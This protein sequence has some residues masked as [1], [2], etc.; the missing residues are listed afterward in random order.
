MPWDAPDRETGPEPA[1]RPA[2]P[3]L[4][5][6]ALLTTRWGIWAGAL[7]LLMAA[8]FLVRYAVEQ[9]LLGPAVRCTLAALLGLTFIVGA[10]WLRRRDKA[11][12]SPPDA[13]AEDLPGRD[14]PG[15]SE[16]DR[17]L[18]PGDGA[19]AQAAP[20]FAFGP[21]LAPAALAAGGVGAL[22]GAAYGAGPLYGLIS[23]L[24][25][26]VLMA[27]ASLAGLALAL[28]H[29]QMVAAIGLVGAFVTPLLVQTQEPSLPGL[30]AYLLFVAAAALAVVRYTAWVWLGWATTIAGAIWVLTALAMG[31]G[32]DAW[33]PAFFVP[34]VATLNLWLLPPAALDHPIGRRLAWVPVAVLGLTGLALCNDLQSWETRAGVLLLAPLT[35]AKAAQEAR[36]RLLPFLAA[37]LALLL[38][39]FWSMD[40]T[41]W[42]GPLDHP[43]NWTPEVVRALI[44]TAALI[45]GFF[46]AAGL[47]FQNRRPQPLPWASLTA[48]VPV[49][50]LAI[51]YW[52]VALFQTR[53]DWA[54]VAFALS[55]GLTGAASLTMRGTG[56]FGVTAWAA[57]EDAHLHR[58][59][60]G[61]HAAGAVAALSL[62][63]AMVLAD[64]WLTL[65][66]S[67]MLPALAWVEAQSDLPPLRRVALAVAIL[68]LLRLLANWYVLDYAFGR[69]PL[70][71]GLLAAY[72]VPAA[73]FWI[74]A[75]MFRRRGDDV[76]VAVLEAGSM[77]FATVLVALEIRQAA[78]EGSLTGGSFSFGEAALHVSSLAAMSV[79]TMRIATRLQ[80]PVLDW[81]WRVQGALALFGGVALLVPGNPLFT[82]QP[83]GAWPLADW[84][85][86]A[87]LLPAG[88]AVLAMHHP[89]TGQP[90]LL[91]R[92]LGLYAM[93][94]GF[95]WL[96]LE[97]RHLF[98]GESI[99]VW[100]GVEDAELWAWSAAWIASGALLLLFGLRRSE[101]PL[102]LGGL[103]LI[104]L[105]TAKVFIVDMSGLQGL[106]RVLSFLGLGLALIGLGTAYRRLAG[107][108]ER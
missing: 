64:Q 28:L 75:R 38:F 42:P 62:A 5:L 77:A 30:F 26:F 82:N 95:V 91:R 20:S 107:R 68:V 47:W 61:V 54:I 78:G 1:P 52:R 3:A 57:S 21:D 44:A 49:L 98:H 31:P 76:T 65:A 41:D 11:V 70:L 89:A 25:A 66:V 6:E 100:K 85:L 45:A 105:T 17:D 79:V 56:F 106:W 4:D 12:A 60:A 2:R 86:P 87:Y 71:N 15:S 35:V 16:P 13:Q 96:T 73:A 63:C 58:Q 14:T 80:R 32:V 40:I 92:L 39:A 29:G 48:S 36:L 69:L 84:L 18:P 101:R 8:I 53:A 22:F 90:I 46:A 72:G 83:V 50:A 81:S 103:A 7:A 94:A 67:L 59:I 102:R 99:A 93:A 74:A 43:R 37:L 104:A 10:E 55:A 97:V 23:P 51:C 88:L 19:S 9:E 108:S 27:A 24:L 34:A 33:A